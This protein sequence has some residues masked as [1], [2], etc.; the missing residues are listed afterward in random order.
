MLSLSE[1]D[2]WR[3]VEV[4]WIVLF[5]FCHFKVGLKDSSMQKVNWS[6]RSGESYAEFKKK[7]GQKFSFVSQVSQKASLLRNEKSSKK[8]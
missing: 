5:D 7:V 2:Y 3:K 8:L 6:L 4:D 1:L